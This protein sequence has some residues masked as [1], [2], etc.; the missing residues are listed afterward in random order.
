MMSR[1]CCRREG[2]QEIERGTL[3]SQN[4]SSGASQFKKDSVSC[5][6]LCPSVTFHSISIDGIDLLKYFVD[7]RSSCDGRV[8]PS[9]DG[10]SS[11]LC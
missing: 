5:R 7:P 6:A 9:N 1:G 3:G 8:L 2:L 11:L 10:G 4:G